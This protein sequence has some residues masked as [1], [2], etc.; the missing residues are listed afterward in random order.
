V[1]FIRDRAD[2]RFLPSR[3]HFALFRLGAWLRLIT[4][5]PQPQPG[6]AMA[7]DHDQSAVEHHTVA[8]GFFLITTAY[9]A[10]ILSRQMNIVLAFVCAMAIAAVL[11]QIPMFA[12][13]W[14]LS[15]LK[16]GRN[17]L[18]EVSAVTVFL[19]LLA[20]I[21]F[22]SASGWPRAIAWMMLLLI[23][24]NVIAAGVLWLLRD[25]VSEAERRFGA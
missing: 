3:Y 7:S 13:G 19:F 18:R 5:P 17:N 21:Y 12:V 15:A 1:R 16:P 4:T 2:A 25:R 22:A 11:V 9:V 23:G 8:W 14:V 24:S 6:L 20:S 10:A